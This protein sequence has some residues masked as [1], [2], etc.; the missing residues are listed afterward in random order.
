MSHEHAS[1]PPG[2]SSGGDGPKPDGPEIMD[3]RPLVQDPSVTPI[4]WLLSHHRRRGLPR[5]STL[6]I[7]A[8]WVALFVTYLLVAPGA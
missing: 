1:P 2:D 3:H 4:A 8:V 5:I 6:I 7:A